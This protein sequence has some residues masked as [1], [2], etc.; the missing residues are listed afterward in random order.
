MS[1]LT[2]FDGSYLEIQPEFPRRE[3]REP[4]GDGGLQFRG[5]PVVG[6]V[7]E[8]GITERGF[9]CPLSGQWFRRGPGEHVEIGSLEREFVLHPEAAEYLAAWA[10]DL[11]QELEEIKLQ[12]ML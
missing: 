9:P 7:Q 4:G 12:P 5:Q 2:Y 8:H 3:V 6:V 10:P 11:I 1:S